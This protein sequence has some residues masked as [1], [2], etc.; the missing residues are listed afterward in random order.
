MKN[1]LEFAKELLREDGVIFV[2][3]D[4]NEQAYLKVLM[5]S[6]FG[7]DN[8]VANIIWN[9]INSVLKQSNFIRKEHEFV[10]VYAK[11]IKLL[12]F[13]KLENTMNFKNIDNDPRGEWFSSNAASPNQ[14]S[15]KNK[16]AIL[17]PNGDECIRNWKFS[18]EQFKNG[19]VSL[20]FKGGNVPRLKI[21]KNE[22]D[23][24]SKIESSIF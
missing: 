19:E 10:L 13:N 12:K 5:D 16:F 6:I 22:Y 2:Q 4:D 9:S 21:Y 23:K 15:S 17:L 1:R 20:Y 24:L 14:K 8:F 18:Y 3:I 7:R 11:D